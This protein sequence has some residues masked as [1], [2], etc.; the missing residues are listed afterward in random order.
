MSTAPQRVVFDC[1]IFAQALISDSGPAAECVE[2]AR[3]GTIRLVLSDYVI[4]EVRELPSKLP[5]RL[6]V[7]NERVEAFLNEVA[8]LAEMF[9]DV[10]EV[11]RHPVDADDSHYV[12]LALAASATLITTRDRHLLDLMD[13]TQPHGRAF[14]QQFPQL[15]SVRPDELVRRVRSA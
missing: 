10:P 8:P 15:E 5:A 6:L 14:H 9:N 3:S 12:N 11:Y 1:V 7:T 13:D 2:L 4:T